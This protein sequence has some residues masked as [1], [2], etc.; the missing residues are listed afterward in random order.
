MFSRIVSK[1]LV[2]K[3]VL[4]GR[5]EEVLFLVFMILGF[6]GG[7]VGEDVE[8]KDRGGGNRGTGDNISGAVRNIEEGIILW[9]VK[10]GP[11]ELRGG[12]TWGRDNG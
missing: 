1:V 10:D 12:G 7:N 5:R 11:G 2:D 6:V 8:A 4:G 3:G 9:V